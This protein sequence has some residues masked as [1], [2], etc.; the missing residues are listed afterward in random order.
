M[1]ADPDY[2]AAYVRDHV[3]RLLLAHTVNIVQIDATPG[4]PE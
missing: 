2:S 1:N 4:S 3:Q